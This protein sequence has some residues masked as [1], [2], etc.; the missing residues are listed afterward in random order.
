MLWGAPQRARTEPERCP[1]QGLGLA[2]PNRK[3]I[4]VGRGIPGYIPGNLQPSASTSSH[5][6]PHGTPG[7]AG[8]AGQALRN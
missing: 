7:Q 1:G 6:T 3:S 2:A 8:Q 5:G 4:S